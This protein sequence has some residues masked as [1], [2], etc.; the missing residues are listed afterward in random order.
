MTD[1]APVPPDDREIARSAAS[2]AEAA[3]AAAPRLSNKVIWSAIALLRATGQLDAALELLDGIERRDGATAKSQEERARLAF[4]RGDHAQAL[5]IFTGRYLEKPSP[6]AAAAL[7]R[8]HL[9]CRNLDEAARISADLIAGH[10]ELL[11]VQQCA[12]DV[13]RSR[14]DNERARSYLFGILDHRPEHVGSLLALSELALAES[15]HDSARAFFKRALSGE[16]DLTANQLASASAVAAGIGDGALASEFKER[17]TSMQRNRLAESI[18]QLLAEIGDLPAAATMLNG[19]QRPSTT[20]ATRRERSAAPAREHTGA[21]ERPG[22]PAAPIPPGV[23]EALHHHF[24]HESL[25]PGQAAVIAQVLQRVDTLAIMPTGAGKSLTFQLPAMIDEGTTLVISPLIALMKDQV[26][27]LPYSVGSRTTLINSTISA[28]EMRTRLDLLREGQYKLVYVAP[29]RLRNHG[30]LRALRSAGVSRVVVDEAHCISMWGHDFRPDYLFIPRALEELGHPPL[31]AITATA[32]PAMVDQIAAGLG[33]SVEVVR[34]SVFRPNLR[35]EV[36]HVEKKEQK[37]QKVA[38]I[39]RSE[40]GSGIVYVSSRRDAESIAALLRDRGVG[41]IPY[42]AGLDQAVRSRNQEQF[43]A[44]NVR[45]V[46]ATVAFGMGVDKANVRFIVHVMPPRSLE[47]YAQESG[48]AGRDGEPAR[49][50]L[51]VSPHDRS[52]LNLVARRDEIELADLRKVYALLRRHAHGA[53]AVVEP[54]GLRVPSDNP[55][56]EPDPRIAL[57]VLEQAG[58]VRRHPD[59]PLT[60]DIR[61]APIGSGA[62]ELA[63]EQ[64]LWRSIEPALPEQWRQRGSCTVVTAELCDLLGIT[65]VELDRALDAQP[66]VN[67]R[68]GTRAMCLAMPPVSGDAAGVLQSLLDS[69]RREAQERIAQVMAYAHSQTCRHQVLAAHLGERM[70]PC[71]TSCDVCTGTAQVLTTS[72]SAR[73]LRVALTAPD[74]HAVLIALRTLPFPVGKPGLVRLLSGSVESRIREDRSPAFGALRPFPKSKIET[75]VDQLI[76]DGFIHRDEQHEYKLLSLTQKGGAAGP[77][78]L[79]RYADSV[80]SVGSNADHDLAES[81]RVLYDRL[82]EWRRAKAVEEE[83]PPYVVAHNSM[84]RN[85]AVARPATKAALMAV[86]GFG[87]TRV[88]RYGGEILSVIGEG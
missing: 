23:I 67:R 57:G 70:D 13:A 11:T 5:D 9:E 41:A 61:R 36:I 64:E 87:A 10:A 30:F 7:S 88:E 44:G 75:L 28:D 76:Q 69:A 18:S 21:I 8:L 71:R 65:P 25:R 42:H 6:S 82:T 31:L 46:V 12:I 52:Q 66:G 49:C 1:S 77:A 38:E 85:L 40:R 27:S 35:Y 19:A 34:T 68:E 48:R 60:Y 50:I 84:L 53:W 56:N 63:G 17:S 33:R 14:G 22:D 47:A 86:P 62:T 54:Q 39:C 58:L 3:T 73:Q 37:L 15:D 83:V 79:L 59:A 45:V 20:S 16:G 29:E 80:R 78:D 55:D 32:T 24:G 81:D 74:V 4:A 43:M 26:E 51:L 72:A 2:L